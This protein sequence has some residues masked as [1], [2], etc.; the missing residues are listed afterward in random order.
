L[1]AGVI[2]LPRGVD[3]QDAFRIFYSVPGVT[4]ETGVEFL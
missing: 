3:A 4:G 2:R 1:V